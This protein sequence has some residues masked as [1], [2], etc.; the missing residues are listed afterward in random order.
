VF[1]TVCTKDRKPWVANSDVHELLRTVWTDAKAWL[2][3]R[4]VLMPDHVHLFCAPNE[5]GYVGG[6]GS[7]QATGGEDG[8]AGASP[9]QLEP[10]LPPLDNWVRYW[11]SQF[12]KR[13][14]NS[15]RRWQPDHWDT[16]L[17]HEESYDAKW[18]YVRNN[19]VRAG[20]V[21]HPEDWHYSGEIHV[22]SW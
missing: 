16:R 8:S 2:V 6:R 1:L 9:S 22:L 11:K 18:E 13:G 20:L 15:G 19:P 3:G 7:R 5:E 4:Y 12:S 21:V 10:A 17:R 14:Q